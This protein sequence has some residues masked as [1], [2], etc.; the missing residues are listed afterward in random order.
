MDVR[1]R[2]AVGSGDGLP[3][4]G[5]VR[6]CKLLLLQPTGTAPGKNVINVMFQ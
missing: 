4:F 5:S 2:A 3:A 6:L 1:F